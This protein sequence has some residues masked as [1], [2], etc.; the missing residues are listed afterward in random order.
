MKQYTPLMIIICCICIITYLIS[1]IYYGYSRWSMMDMQVLMGVWFIV[2]GVMKLFDLK[3][4][5]HMF[6]RY[7]PLALHI[8]L[9]ARIFPYIEI[10]LGMW[11]LYDTM[12]RYQVPLNIVTIIITSITTYGIWVR[13]YHRDQLTCVC[14]GTKISTPLWWPSLIEQ[15]VM[16]LMAIWMIMVY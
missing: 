9:Y 3:W 6:A 10:W 4:F 15:W 11:Y 2:F 13:L 12:M 5:A 1:H 16:C 7:D 14:M 8:P